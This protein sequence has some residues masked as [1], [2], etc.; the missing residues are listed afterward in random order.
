MRDTASS[1]RGSPT[2]YGTPPPAR[3]VRVDVGDRAVAIEIT[4]RPA[5][6]GRHRPAG[7]GSGACRRAAA[8]L[9]GTA[10]GAGLTGGAGG[11]GPA[12]PPP[13]PPPS[14]GR[15]RDGHISVL[16]G[17][18]PLAGP[19]GIPSILGDEDDIDV[20]GEARDG[21]EAVEAAVREMPDVVLM[22][23]RMARMDGL[24]AT[25][26][27]TAHPGCGPRRSSSSPRSTST[28]TCSGHSRPAP[29]LS[30]SRGSAADADRRGADGGRR[31]RPARA[32]RRPADR[33][34]RQRR[35]GGVPAGFPL[36]STLTAR[37][38]ELLRLIAAGRTNTEIADSCSSAR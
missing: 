12:S 18:R 28:S 16:G 26:L 14:A 17:R 25:R 29:A 3:R 9:G 13:P 36:P 32:E 2:C 1:R 5:P 20:V 22:D 35:T 6:A 10:G 11:C 37:E 31:R 15:H 34:L 23:I 33:G 27:I 4:T 19:R 38:V 7:T 24:E 8:A 30:C 21:A